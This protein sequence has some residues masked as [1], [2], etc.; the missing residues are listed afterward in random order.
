MNVLKVGYV[1]IECEMV[2][3]EEKQAC[4]ANSQLCDALKDAGIIECVMK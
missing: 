4:G 3:K 2:K 1:Y